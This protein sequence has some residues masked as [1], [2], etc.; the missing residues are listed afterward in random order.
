MLSRNLIIF[1]ILAYLVVTVAAA[2]VEDKE[3]EEVENDDTD[4]ADDEISEEDRDGVVIPQW[5]TTSS[6]EKGPESMPGSVSEQVQV[7]GEKKI[8]E[9]KFM[10]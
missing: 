2:P 8:G 1:P 10:T 7:V 5:P 4:D 9:N 3:T 6:K